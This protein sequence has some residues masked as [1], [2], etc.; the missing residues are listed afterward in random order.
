MMT[1]EQHIAQHG[2]VLDRYQLEGGVW[3]PHAP[4]LVNRDFDFALAMALEGGLGAGLAA[5]KRK[6][7]NEERAAELAALTLPESAE[8]LLFKLRCLGTHVYFVLWEG[9]DPGLRAVIDAS[10]GDD[11]VVDTKPTDALTEAI[12][13]VL[14]SLADHNE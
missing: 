7:E 3:L 11:R 14:A 12:I 10:T 9:K 6:K 13:D 5:D 1:P 8:E 4:V 2:T